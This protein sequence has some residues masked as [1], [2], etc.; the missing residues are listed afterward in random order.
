[1]IIQCLSLVFLAEAE[2]DRKHPVAG[3]E[4]EF[5]HAQST[6]SR[7]H[8]ANDGQLACW[9]SRRRREIE[10]RALR[11]RAQPAKSGR[12][13]SAAPWRLPSLG[14]YGNLTMRGMPI[15]W[16]ACDA[17]LQSLQ[18]RGGGARDLRL[19]KRAIKE[20][21]GST[22]QSANLLA[23][24]LRRHSPFAGS[25]RVIFGGFK[26][27]ASASCRNNAWQHARF[28]PRTL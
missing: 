3:M 17:L 16:L 21:R 4:D 10:A 5:V 7:A 26:K 15:S 28:S 2:Q 9:R 1:M 23:L 27:S 6:L 25:A 20:Q 24:G 8:A 14:K 11:M 22:C 13:F 12:R 19:T 18:K